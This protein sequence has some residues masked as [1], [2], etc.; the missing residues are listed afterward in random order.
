MVLANERR[1][2]KE[3]VIKYTERL[4]LR[5]QYLNAIQAQYQ[6]KLIPYQPLCLF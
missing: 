4:V 2:D 6:R 5:P 3:T 1:F